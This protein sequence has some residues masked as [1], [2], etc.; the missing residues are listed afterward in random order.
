MKMNCLI[1][2]KDKQQGKNLNL[3]LKIREISSTKG[4]SATHKTL[5]QHKMDSESYTRV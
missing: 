1:E 4:T 2:E 5:V 3:S